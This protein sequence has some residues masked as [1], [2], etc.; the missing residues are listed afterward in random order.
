MRIGHTLRKLRKDRGLRQ[1]KAA[2]EIG[3]SQ[4]YLSQIEGDLREPSID[5]LKK[6]SSYYNIPVPVIFFSSLSEE[7]V[8]ENKLPA[9]RILRPIID[10]LIDEIY[11]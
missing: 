4:T 3:I 7:D 11:S 2:A 1:L 6:F 10:N 8:A 9:Y 5:I